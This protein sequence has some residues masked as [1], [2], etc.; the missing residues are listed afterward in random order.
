MKR[1]DDIIR[2][3]EIQKSKRRRGKKTKTR[4]AGRRKRKWWELE[5]EESR[6]KKENKKIEMRGRRRRGGQHYEPPK[7]ERRRRKIRIESKEEDG[8]RKEGGKWVMNERSNLGIGEEKGGTWGFGE[9]IK[10]KM[11]IMVKQEN[12]NR[13]EA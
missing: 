12:P 9:M 5:A 8:D 10:R 7:L 13:K 6:R 3:G 4:I 2:R 1:K 11:G